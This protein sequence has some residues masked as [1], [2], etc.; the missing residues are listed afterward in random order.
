MELCGSVKNF[1]D[2]ARS[3]SKCRENVLCWDVKQ[4]IRTG[5]ENQIIHLIGQLN[6][7]RIRQET[8]IQAII[9][10]AQDFPAN[11]FD[12][13]LKEKYKKPRKNARRF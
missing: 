5:C 10:N 7:S 8:F 9:F 6:L 12:P 1:M 3:F 2:V 11:C 4:K 13:K